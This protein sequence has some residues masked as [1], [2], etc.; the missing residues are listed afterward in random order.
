MPKKKKGKRLN[1]K[2]EETKRQLEFKE[3][4]QEYAIIEKALGN[5]R[6]HLQC[7]D[8]KQRLG[9]LR[10]KMKKKVWVRVGDLVIVK[11]WTVQEDTKG[12]VVFRYTKTQANKIKDKVPEFLR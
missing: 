12:D 1:N 9:I 7:M 6:F 3:D 4:G 5:G 11:K 8:G 10:G 2:K